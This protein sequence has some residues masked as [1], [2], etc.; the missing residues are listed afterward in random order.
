MCCLVAVLVFLGPRA[1]GLIW[2][3]A[4]PARWGQAFS[5][6]II[7][8]LGLLF[9]PWTTLAWVFVS[10]M[11]SPVWT[12]RV[13]IGIFARLRVVRGERLQAARISAFNRRSPPVS[14]GRASRPGQPS[15][16]SSSRA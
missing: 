7:G 6:D 5:S 11:G 3:L 15:G 12:S 16:A 10:P 2:W 1:A 4:E 13:I 9:L 14:G 8:I